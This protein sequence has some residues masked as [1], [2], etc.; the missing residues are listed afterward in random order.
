MSWVATASITSLA[1]GVGSSIF[2]AKHSKD[3]ASAQAQVARDQAQKLRE[4]AM[5]SAQASEREIANLRT[6]RS[7]D[8]PAFRQAA[9]TAMIQAQQGVER[10]ARMRA[11]GQTSGAVREALFGDQ[12]QQYIGREYQR[13]Q[14][15]AGLTE[16]ILKAT[17]LQQERALAVEAQAG[18]MEYAGQTD[19]LRIRAEAGSLMGNILGA[20]GQAASAF[21]TSMQAQGAQAEKTAQAV[22]SEN[23]WL[24]F[25][26]AEAGLTMPGQVAPPPNSVGGKMIGSQSY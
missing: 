16:Q 12:F 18:Q 5:V 14:Q 22:E 9:E 4:R 15:Y 20:V 8:I 25:A 7:M 17:E 6:L 1:A 2:S 3:L 26:Y 10:M 13:L 23:K 11:V 19:A 24:Q 21:A